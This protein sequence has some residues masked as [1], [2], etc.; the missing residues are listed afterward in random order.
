MTRGESPAPHPVAAKA[1]L[2][3]QRS[4]SCKRQMQTEELGFCSSG[5]QG[6]MST[7]WGKWDRKPS[8]Y[9]ETVVETSTLQ[10]EILLRVPGKI[11]NNNKSNN[12][13][14]YPVPGSV[15]SALYAQKN[16]VR[17]LVSPFYQW[18]AQGDTNCDLCMQDSNPDWQATEPE[19]LTTSLYCL[20]GV[21]MQW[22]GQE[23]PGK[24]SS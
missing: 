6:C 18:L 4:S 11:N 20:L 5:F 13:G 16:S 8:P 24:L 22:K 7:S 9:L 17:Y 1:P 19:F 23:I 15:V 14:I 12:G 10:R 21:T 2:S 3:Q